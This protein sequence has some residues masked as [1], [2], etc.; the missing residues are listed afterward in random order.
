MAIRA[1]V[2]LHS[3]THTQSLVTLSFVAAT[4]PENE[5]WAQ[6]TPSLQLTMSVKPEVAVHFVLGAEYILPFQMVTEE[7]KS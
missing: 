7:V 1:K 3:I 6:W 5:E 2:I 4:G